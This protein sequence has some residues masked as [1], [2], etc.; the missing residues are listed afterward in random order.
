MA[1]LI[2]SRLRAR[3]PVCEQPD[4]VTAAVGWVDKPSIVERESACWVSCLNPTYALTTLAALTKANVD[5]N[6]RNRIPTLSVP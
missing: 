3:E 5:A 6:L 4:Y 1:D 2:A